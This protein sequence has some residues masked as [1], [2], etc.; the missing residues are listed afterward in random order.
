MAQIA[1]PHKL[2]PIVA[3]CEAAY[4]DA[5]RKGYAES[6]D[7]VAAVADLQS[8]YKALAIANVN[9]TTARGLFAIA[10][11]TL[12][13]HRASRAVRR[14][15]VKIQTT[16]EQVSAEDRLYGRFQSLFGSTYPEIEITDRDEAMA[17]GAPD[18]SSQPQS[19]SAPDTVQASGEP[20]TE[21]AS[22]G[23]SNEAV[24]E[25]ELSRKLGSAGDD[26]AVRD[27]YKNLNREDQRLGNEFIRILGL[28]KKPK[29]LDRIVTL[30]R[31]TNTS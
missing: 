1:I 22:P 25:E 24:E 13:A 29:D 11:A 23:I 5:S 16:L 8:A 26:A 31:I 6:P 27:A 9:L 28:I 17:A 19:T 15:C 20:N 4:A 7:V 21:V 3:T 18:T 30:V 14:A 10:F 2:L 12:H